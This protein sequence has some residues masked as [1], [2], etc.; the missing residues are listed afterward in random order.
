VDGQWGVSLRYQ[1]ADTQLNLGL[2]AMN[3]HDKAPQFSTNVKGEGLV[4]WTYPEDRKLFGASVNFPVGDWA[5]GSELSYRPRDAV[6]LNANA[7]GCASQN[8]NC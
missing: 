7:S 6:A 2:Y 8:G 1:P 3:Y 4:G 5:V